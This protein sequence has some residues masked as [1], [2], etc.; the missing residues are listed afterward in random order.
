MGFYPQTKFWAPLLGA[1]NPQTE[2][3]FQIFFLDFGCLL[4]VCNFLGTKSP[5][6][7][8]VAKGVA[9]QPPKW[10]QII[11]LYCPTLINKFTF[12]RRKFDGKKC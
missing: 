4:D 1:N 11:W 9:R 10:G 8:K 3:I 2:N 5:N 12:K 6:N 7:F